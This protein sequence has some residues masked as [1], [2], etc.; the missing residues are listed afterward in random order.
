MQEGSLLSA[1]PTAL[2]VCR[3]FDDD[4]SDTLIVCRFF[5]DGHSDWCEVMPH[6]S[7]DLYLSNNE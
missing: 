7:F 3:F 1:P 6:C 2:I 4:H 5:V